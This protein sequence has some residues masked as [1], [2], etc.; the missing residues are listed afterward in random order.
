MRL[1]RPVA[2]CAGFL[3]SILAL[4]A[5]AGT[6]TQTQ[7]ATQSFSL[8][9]LTIGSEALVPNSFW[10]LTFAPFV[11][12]AL[13]SV[14]FSIQPTASASFTVASGGAGGGLVF[15]F[16]D[17][18]N[19]GAFYGTGSPVAG[20]GHGGGPGTYSVSNTGIS[21]NPGE[22]VSN[23]TIGAMFTATDPLVLT[24]SNGSSPVLYFGGSGSIASISGSASFTATL[25][26]TFD[27]DG[28]LYGEST[29][30]P[31]PGTL[32]LLVPVLG[33]L[34]SRRRRR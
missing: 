28:A 3:A 11:G 12:S 8:S 34:A 31:E 25:T 4:P 21:Q 26:Y 33:V 32:A 19:S 27:G 16:T 9:P 14:T 6:L 20:V 1:V 18:L 23:G 5:F 15:G 2:V 10:S 30:T 29:S 24:L 17:Y 7:T 22:L 13:T